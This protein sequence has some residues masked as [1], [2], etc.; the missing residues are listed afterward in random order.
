MGKWQLRF[1][2][3]QTKALL[4]AYERDLIKRGKS[5]E[6]ARVVQIGCRAREAGYFAFNDFLR[7]CKWKS[8]RNQPRYSK[9]SP[10]LVAEITRIALAC[11]SETLRPEVLQRLHGV[12][13]PVASFLLHIA[14]SSPYPILDKRALWSWG[15]DKPPTYNFQFWWDY[16]QQC[17]KLAQSLKVDMRTLDRALWQYSKEHQKS[18]C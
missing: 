6:E 16:V 10:E 14:H 4:A 11:P 2:P 15:F 9:N 18:L 8:P 12:G 3:S 5:E 13:F 7:A 17:R 1:D